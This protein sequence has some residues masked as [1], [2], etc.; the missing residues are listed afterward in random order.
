LL[1]QSKLKYYTVSV[2]GEPSPEFVDDVAKEYRKRPVNVVVAV[3]GGSAI[4]AGKAVSAMLA[5]EGSVKEYLEGV[6]TRKP[7]GMKA[8]FIAVPT[9]AGTGCE[10]TKNAVLS[11]VGKDGYKKSLRHDAFVPDV[12]LVDPELALSCPP[13]VTASCGM[14]AISQLIEA[15]TSKNANPFTDALARSGLQAAAGAFLPLATGR[16]DDIVLRGKMAYAALSSGIVLAQAGLGT[17]HG[18]AGPA[19]GLFP[20]P[21]GAACAALLVP[22]LKRVVSRLK[23]GPS[24]G[25]E[26][27]AEAG[28]IISGAHGGSDSQC[29]DL[30]VST[31]A[32]WVEMTA[33]PKLGAFGV[34]EDISAIVRSADNKSSPVGLSPDEIAAALLEAL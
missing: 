2:K 17:V 27:F 31:L 3:G 18:I 10:A 13:H 30:L 23:E 22:V 32:Q 29:A 12:A 14:D 6:G 15:Y 8:P 9:T 24:S 5:E 1:D 33:I 20:V 28:R 19:G 7:S 4:D 25:L 11:R 16:G 26:K 21:H 34:A